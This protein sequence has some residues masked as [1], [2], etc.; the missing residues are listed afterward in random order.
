MLDHVLRGI[1]CCA[2]SCFSPLGEDTVYLRQEGNANS[3]VEAVLKIDPELH[4][5]VRMNATCMEAGPFACLISSVGS[6]VSGEP[7]FCMLPVRWHC[8]LLQTSTTTQKYL[9]DYDKTQAFVVYDAE[10]MVRLVLL[11]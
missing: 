1:P 3:D 7:L 11:N 2:Q 6:S 4:T 9:I 10:T 8:R 5:G